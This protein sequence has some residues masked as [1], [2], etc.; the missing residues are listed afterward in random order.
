MYRRAAVAI[1]ATALMPVGCAV[2][3][4]DASSS[5]TR[6]IVLFDGA[7][8][9]EFEPSGFGGDGEVF[10]EDGVLILDQGSPLTGVTWRGAELPRVDYR[11]EFTATRLR[12]SDFFCGLTFPVGE[13][14]L[15]LVLGGWGGA[16]C[17]LSSLDGLDAAENETTTYRSFVNGRAYR[18][19]LEV[20]SDRIEARI[21]GETV[22]TV[23]PR[24]RRLGLRP[25]VERSRPLGFASFAT[26]AGLSGIRL[27]VW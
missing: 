11:L 25:E 27:S 19:L 18:V 1:V 2:V 12:G 26:R 21:D 6:Q 14:H 17:G 7:S 4:S 8:L 20:R 13:A 16:L 3:D 10:V 15:T 9:G 23:D 24:G 22:A 5:P